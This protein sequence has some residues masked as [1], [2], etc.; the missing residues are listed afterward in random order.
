MSII[1]YHRMNQSTFQTVFDFFWYLRVDG[2]YVCVCLNGFAL[3][4]IFIFL[5]SITIWDLKPVFIIF[6]IQGE[7]SE[8]FTTI[9]LFFILQHV[10]ILN[11]IYACFFPKL[12]RFFRLWIMI[13]LI[14]VSPTNSSIKNSK[15]VL[16]FL[17]SLDISVHFVHIYIFCKEWCEPHLKLGLASLLTN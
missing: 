9:F 1:L 16:L 14:G 6:P 2:N 12:T 17:L 4:F 10:F 5:K 3:F 15:I 11:N 13:I 8:V 7:I